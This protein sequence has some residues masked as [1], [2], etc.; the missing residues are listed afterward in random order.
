MLHIKFMM[1]VVAMLVPYYLLVQRSCHQ[2]FSTKHKLNT[3]S[4]TKSDLVAMYDKM[5]DIP[6]TPHFIEAQDYT[7][8]ANIEFQ[9]NMSTL[10]LEKN[11]RLSSSKCTKHIKPRYF[12]IQYYYHT[13]EIDLRYCPTDCGLTSLLN[14]SKALKS[15][16]CVSF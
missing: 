10:F 11:G 15:V 12:L 14:L 5:G 6:R 9:D 4:S 13:G 8:F 16:K 3:K 7:I 1:T 2:F